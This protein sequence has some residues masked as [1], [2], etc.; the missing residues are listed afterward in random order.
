[1][2]MSTDRAFDQSNDLAAELEAVDMLARGESPS[3]H[4]DDTIDGL[5]T[6]NISEPISTSQAYKFGFESSQPGLLRI[7][8]EFLVFIVCYLILGTII[9]VA[10]YNLSTNDSEH[11]P[12]W[13]N[14]LLSA[15]CL[16]IP[17]PTPGFG[18]MIKP[19]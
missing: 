8:K 1:M 17:N 11:F 10:L 4:G 2:A 14:T 7:P 18:Q 6:A 13:S 16:C 12:F 5:S 15:M 9:S 19:K 3:F